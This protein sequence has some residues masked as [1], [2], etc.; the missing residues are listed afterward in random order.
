MTPKF[1]AV[2]DMCIENGLKLGF[3]R[4]HKHNDQPTEQQIIEKQF[5]AI[6]DEIY[7]WFD[8]EDKYAE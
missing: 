4:A 7:E 2:L 1:N 6:M 8:F 5:Q 3:S